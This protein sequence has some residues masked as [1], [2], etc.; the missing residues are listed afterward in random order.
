MDD[1]LP[2]IY[3]LLNGGSRVARKLESEVR[4]IVIG[5]IEHVH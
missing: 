3:G 4:S 5:F 2:V 1:T